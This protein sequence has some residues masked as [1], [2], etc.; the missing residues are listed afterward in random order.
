MDFL[1]SLL[2][3]REANK[4]GLFE[5]ITLFQIFLHDFLKVSILNI[6]KQ[7]FVKL[8]HVSSVVKQHTVHFKGLT[9]LTA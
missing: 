6:E 7:K 9:K 2:K 1:I 5:T 8:G 3:V 4:T